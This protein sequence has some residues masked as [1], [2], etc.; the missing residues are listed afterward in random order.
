MKVKTQIKSGKIC[1]RV[2]SAVSKASAKTKSAW[3]RLP[4]WLRWPW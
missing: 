3:R 2:Q 4:N 1:D